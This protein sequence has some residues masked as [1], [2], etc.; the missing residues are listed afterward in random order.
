LGMPDTLRDLGYRL[1]IASY[2]ISRWST[3]ARNHMVWSH[4]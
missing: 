3:L 2:I 4:I 1:V